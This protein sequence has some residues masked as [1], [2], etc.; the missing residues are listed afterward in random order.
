MWNK[1]L[2]EFAIVERLCSIDRRRD[3]RTDIVLTDMPL[4]LRLPHEHSGLCSRATQDQ[5]ATCEVN[6]IGKVFQSE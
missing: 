1:L 3:V 5:R 2:R 4:K 6:S